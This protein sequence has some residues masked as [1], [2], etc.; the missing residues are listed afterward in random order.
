VHGTATL[1]YF[2]WREHALSRLRHRSHGLLGLQALVF[3]NKQS[4][5]RSSAILGIVVRYWASSCET[6]HRRA[7]L[8][9]IVRYWASSCDT[10]HRRAILGTVVRYSASSNTQSTWRTWG[11]P[12][13]AKRVLAT[14]ART[15]RRSARTSRPHGAALRC[16][17]WHSCAL[18]GPALMAPFT[19]GAVSWGGRGGG[20]GFRVS[21]RNIMIQVEGTRIG[22]RGVA[23]SH[24]PAS[25]RVGAL[26]FRWC[27][28]RCGGNPNRT[29]AFGFQVAIFQV[30][31][32][33]PAGGRGPPGPGLTVPN[34]EKPT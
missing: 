26:R 34:L 17:A 13:C 1:R 4:S 5:W 16:F 11:T 15:K 22:S 21:P 19:R 12:V 7:I 18:L 9:I 25:D 2:T 3:G 10:R 24:G 14:C 6:R 28:A 32:A 31:C 33:R 30:Q 27:D 29:V 8:G 23:C 20:V